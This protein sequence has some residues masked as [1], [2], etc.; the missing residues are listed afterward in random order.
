MQCARN[1]GRAPAFARRSLPRSP[2]PVALAGCGMPGAPQPPSLHLPVRVG[3]LSAVRTGNQV[4]LTWSMPKRD[5]DKVPLKGNVTVRICRNES[6]L[7]GCSAAATMQLAPG[8]DGAFTDT[9]PPALAAGAPRVLTYFVELDNRKGRSAGLSN[10]AQILAG[11]APAAVDGLAAEMRRDGVL[12]RWA[13]APSDAAPVAVRLV[14]KLVTPPA[15]PRRKKIRARAR[16]LRAPS[17]RSAPCW[18]SPARTWTALSTAASASARPMSIARNA[19]PASSSTEKRWNSPGRSR[20][21]VRIEAVNVFPPAVPR[22]LA[23][24]ATAGEA[25]AGPAIDLSWQPDTEADLA[26]Y[27][28][29]R[30]EPERR[31]SSWQRISPAQPVVG[32]GFHDANVQPG[33]TYR[34]CGERHRPAGAR[35]RALGRGRGNGSRAIASAPRQGEKMKYCRFLLGGQ[36]QYGAVEDRNGELWI[37]GP[38]ACARGRSALPPRAWKRTPSFSFRFE[39]M[40]LSAADLLPPVTPSKIICVGRN[41]RE[42]V[43]GAGQRNARRA[44][45]LLQAASSLLRPAARCVLP[46]A[47]ERVDFEGELALVIGRRTRNL[48]PEDDWREVVRGFTLAND[49]SARD[50]QKKDEQWT[51]AK[52]F[53][54]FCPVGPMVSDELDLEAGVTIETRVNGELRQHGS[55]LDFIFPVPVLLR[56]ITAAITLEPGDLILTGTPS[57]VGPLK[58][59]DRVEVSMPRPRRARKYRGSGVSLRR[60]PVH[61]RRIQ[62]ILKRRGT[63]VP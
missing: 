25:G 5:T 8:A 56:F 18:S 47:S 3:D 61:P 36:T 9:L 55:T 41:Y 2:L 50:L 37:I 7:R 31:E 59:G 46:A 38:D 4:A 58:P 32:P 39:P 30:R 21:P 16:S 10:G 12:L 60:V 49:I 40:P 52:G 35:E 51:R 6:A 48:K 24:V 23:A 19:W 15:N 17:R 14:R 29:Y 53:D 45:A 62:R 28:V 34:V 1:P 13:P 63:L 33:H 42:H 20:S 57:G 11:E 43:R 26:G 22:G 27:V 54:T 44:A